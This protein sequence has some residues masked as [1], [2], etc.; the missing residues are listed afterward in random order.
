MTR[1]RWHRSHWARIWVLAVAFGCGGNGDGSSNQPTPT[2]SLR[3]TVVATVTPSPSRT[4]TAS[5]TPASAGLQGLIVLRREVPSGPQDAVAAPPADWAN[6]PDMESFDRGLGAATL[7]LVGR[8][9]VTI[10]TNPDGTFAAAELPE[11]LSRLEIEK[12]LNGNLIRLAV[13]VPAQTSG[14]LHLLAQVGW[15]ELR[16]VLEGRNGYRSVMQ[17]QDNRHL[18]VRIENGQLVEFSQ[19]SQTWR[20][21]DGDG[22]LEPV[23]CVRALWECGDDFQCEDG[24]ACLCTASCPVCDDCGPGVCGAGDG[25]YAYRCGD[26]GECVEPG[27]SCTCVASCPTCTD[28]SR[29]VCVPSCQ[30]LEL[31]GIQISGSSEVPLG[32]SIQLH[33]VANFSN[34]TTVD[35]TRLVSWQSSDEAVAPVDSWGQV[36]GKAIAAAD[37]V[38]TLGAVQSDPF[39]VRV[40]ERSSLARIIVRNVSC[41]CPVFARPAF[42]ADPGVALPPCVW[43]DAPAVDILPVPWCRDVILVG[44]TVQL[45][46]LGEFAD[47]SVEDVTSE[48]EWTAEPAGVVTVEAG[49]V[50]TRLVGD[51]AIRARMGEVSSE[52][53]RLRVVDRPTP[54]ALRIFAQG[55]VPAVRQGGSGPGVPP[56]IEPAPCLDCDYVSTMLVGDTLPFTASVEYDTGEWEDVTARAAW[57]SDDDLV[58]EF[59]APGML[60][61][62]APGQVRVTATLGALTSNAL[63]VRVVREASVQDLFVYVESNERVVAK[64]GTLFLRANAMYD[65]GFVRDVTEEVVWHSSDERIGS[66]STAGQFTGMAAGVVRVWGELGGRVSNPIELEVYETHEIQYCDPGRVNRAIWSDAFNRVVLESD[67]DRYDIPSTVTLRYTVTETQPHG[68]IFDPCLDLYVFRGT[69]LVRILREE[70][71]GEPFLSGAAPGR[72]DAVLRY[73]TLAFWD[74]RDLHGELVPPGV[75]RIYGRFFLYYDPVVYLDITVGNPGPS[76]TPTPPAVQQGCFL[77]DCAGLFVGGGPGWDRAACCAYART[78]LGPFA[79]SWCERI[80]NGTCAPGACQNP[81]EE[82]VGCCPPNTVCVPEVPPCAEQCCPPGAQCGPEGLPPC[83]NCPESGRL[84]DCTVN[85]HPICPAVVMPVCGCDGKTYPNRCSLAAACV[86]LAREGPCAITATP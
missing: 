43:M 3:S 36:Y 61:G 29:R 20:D 42:P 78:N 63:G 12:V 13:P 37:I 64:G 33:A 83:R 17:V 55:P 24:S 6:G 34:G 7:R 41:S 58:A 51:V 48:A 18:S 81:C 62:K 56:E 73:Q 14:P 31:K 77:R 35:V 86:A 15:G 79:V 59:T 68:G 82:E 75:Y 1:V 40:V 28:C 52:P 32:R 60:S 4:P 71:C 22:V 69:E 46:A 44:R 23:H 47:G 25:G 70:G 80:V 53:F 50:K 76:E 11:E 84:P 57:H 26:H 66:F 9:T 38:A 39:T 74:L 8:E 65:L 49:T 10:A 19:G 85:P 30:P 45:A 27:D 16:V 2:P 67:C 72:E 21:S 54:V 5:P